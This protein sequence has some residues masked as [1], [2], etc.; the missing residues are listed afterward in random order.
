MDSVISFVRRVIPPTETDFYVPASWIFDSAA[1]D[2]DFAGNRYW[3]S[4]DFFANP[5]NLLSISRASIG[6][7]KT[8]AGVLTQ[9]GT[10]TL[11]I[12]T[13]GLLIEDSRQ[14]LATY[15]QDFSNASGWTPTH[16]TVTG[17]ALA[18]P[19]GATTADT[20]VENN[21]DTRHQVTFNAGS[22]SIVSGSNY[23]VS[24]FAKKQNR[25][26]CYISV[27][28]FG[29]NDFFA[30][31]FDLQNGVVGETKVGS[32]TGTIASTSIEELANGWY[33][34]TVVGSL[35]LT[36]CALYYGA[37]PLATGNTWDM[38]NGW[39]TYQGTSIDSISIW[40]G[41]FELGS[42]SSSY[43]PTTT[44]SATRAKDV[45]TSIGDLDTLLGSGTTG[46][47]VVNLIA[48]QPNSGS[49]NVRIIGATTG[50]HAILYWQGT[51]SETNVASYNGTS[52]LAAA[53]GGSQTFPG[54]VKV[55]AAWDAA[56]SRVVLG[57]GGTVSSS[58]SLI[59]NGT[60][61]ALGYSATADQTIFSYFRRVT[62][63]SSKLS[64][65][66]LQSLTSP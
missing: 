57:G 6:Y 66:T 1:I 36:A 4:P 46:S 2:M 24:I 28:G 53:L 21:V 19:D 27:A 9:F 39:P 37:A 50:D 61:A 7:A 60:G 18:A 45:V 20:L 25:N 30:A 3:D 5:T 47:V 43:I 55:A 58:A 34:C 38:V 52:E 49:Q 31:V 54:G 44:T 29:G 64:D 59:G 23:A 63:W 15:S 11:R 13:L 41:Q 56:P 22:I 62:V 8:A 42:F 48:N 40:G 35:A 51:V 10:D 12:T 32:S 16:V 17:D 65:S 26:C 33:R 14:N